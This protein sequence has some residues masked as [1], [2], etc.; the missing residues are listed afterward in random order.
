M[1]NMKDGKELIVIYKGDS[2]YDTLCVFSE[3]LGKSLERLGYQ[4]VTVDLNDENDTNQKIN[5]L[6]GLEVKAF[7]GFNG[8]GAGVQ[9]SDG[10]YLQDAMNGPYYGFFVDHPV[11]Q[12]NRL[13][14]PIRNM[15]AFV[16][17]ESHA[18]YIRIHHPDVQKVQ[19]IPH[20]G[21]MP[22]EVQPYE[23]RTKDVVFLALLSARRKFCI[24]LTNFRNRD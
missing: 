11:Y 15:N 18:D 5:M 12:Y 20:G 19:M 2:K 13:A 10:A 4:I 17:D 3:E 21:I 22:A 1:T 14:A 8:I 16:V 6:A 23:S 9:L 7:I 24:R